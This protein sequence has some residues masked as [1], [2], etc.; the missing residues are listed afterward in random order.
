MI[1]LVFVYLQRSDTL[2][3]LLD[4]VPTVL[5]WF[6]IDYPHYSIFPKR[7]QAK[8]AGKS[9]LSLVQSN[10]TKTDERKA[11]FGSQ[12][13][14]EITMYYPMRSIRT[15]QYKLIENLVFRL[16]FPIDQ[17][18][19][20]SPTFQDILNRTINHEKLNWFKTLDKY[21]NRPPYELYDI[22]SDPYETNNLFEDQ[23]Y[24]FIF[25]D[26]KSRLKSWQNE[27]ADPWL[28]SLGG[29][30]EDSGLYRNYPQC[31]PL[32]NGY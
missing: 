32:Y 3:S 25:A 26:L 22:T 9:L 20:L 29:V 1:S 7:P 27:T 31:L 28:C 23:A 5:D 18:F 10:A 24:R 30:L 8:L 2:V 13:L 4:V 12:S 21:Y 6:S 11:V 14:H 17:D 16:P 15:S 19:Y